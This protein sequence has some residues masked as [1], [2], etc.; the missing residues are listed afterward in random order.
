MPPQSYATRTS[1]ESRD[2]KTTKRDSKQTN[3]KTIT[4]THTHTHKQAHNRTEQNRTQQQ[5][6]DNTQCQ[7]I[8][9]TKLTVRGTTQPL[10][11]KAQILQSTHNCNDAEIAEVSNICA[12]AI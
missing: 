12:F 3:T 7:Y 10:Q 5:Q 9:Y 1:R 8:S 2:D 6:R 11:P 4:L